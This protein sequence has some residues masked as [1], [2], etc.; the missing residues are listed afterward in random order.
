MQYRDPVNQGQQEMR[1]KSASNI[2]KGIGY[3]DS[4][5]A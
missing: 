1:R 4:C 3:A 2:D 5:E